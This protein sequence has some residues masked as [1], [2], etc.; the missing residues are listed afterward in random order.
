MN[1]FALQYPVITLD[2]QELMKAGDSYSLDAVEDVI[3]SLSP[4]EFGTFS[5]LEYETVNKDLK[6]FL[7]IPPYQTIFSDMEMLAEIFNVMKNVK[8]AVPV[9]QVLEY[10]KKHDYHTYRHM[11]VIYALTILLSKTLA[12]EENIQ[13]LEASAG[14]THDLGKINVPLEILKKRQPL[15]QLERKILEHHTLA[16]YILLSYYFSN[17]RSVAAKVARDHHERLNGSG[18]P[19]GIRQKDLLVE[20]VTAVDI[21]DALISPRPYRPV[22]YDNRTALEELTGMAE[23][24]EISWD[25]LQTLVSFNRKTKPHYTEFKVSEEKRGVPPKDNSYGKTAPNEDESAVEE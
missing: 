16:G 21:Y 9:L 17:S 14:P 1:I 5:L 3:S 12:P 20:I 6:H 13:F 4:S 18:Y 19:H 11:L 23:K 2:G 15:T 8:V 22:S 7:A 24:G 25:I 10:F